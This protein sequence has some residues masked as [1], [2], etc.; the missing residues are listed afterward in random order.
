[1][2]ERVGTMT[3]GDLIH[4][5]EAQS[6]ASAADRARCIGEV[7]MDS[8]KVKPGDVFVA[9]KGDVADGHDY[10]E[11][12]LADG[13]SGAI[14]AAAEAPRYN[15]C[16]QSRLLIVSEPLSAVQRMARE[17]R[18]RLS[19]PIIGVTGSNGKTTTRRFIAELLKTERRV[20]ETIGNWNNHI[21][22]PLTLL[23]FSGEEDIGV[24]E[25]AANHVGEIRTLSK[26]AEP[27]IGLITNI[28]YAHVGFFGSLSRT[29][30]AKFEIIAGMKSTEDALMINGDDARLRKVTREAGWK[31]VTFG[32]GRQCRIR[33]QNVTVS[34]NGESS[35]TVDDTPFQLSI[36]GRHF[37]YAVLPAIYLARKYGVGMET[38][39][40]SVESLRPFEMRGGIEEH[41]GISFIVDCYN[42]NPSSMK[43]AIALLKDM[44]GTRRM[45]AIVG[46][47]RELGRYAT[48][49]HRALGRDLAREGVS[50]VVAV[51]EHGED[52][53]RG[54][55]ENAETT[56]DALAVETAA[57]AGR[58]AVNELEKNDVV[59]LKGSRAVELERVMDLYRN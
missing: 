52:I 56:I 24:I 6:S 43:S 30:E 58:W 19:I 59:L 54:A 13:A 5:G 28:G 49:L 46:E 17:Y 35:F 45:V 50:R 40:K 41:K 16:I 37:I 44:A 36:P 31:A 12:A 14:V 23:R 18:K 21:G 33:A 32:F 15:E 26:I 10:V 53:V 27:T 1:M 42:A 29:T 57:E 3:L 55:R 38:I 48:R 11:K 8:R 25:L 47:M 4:W 20:G 22:V 39:R 9:L 34:E 2:S 7:W 51:G